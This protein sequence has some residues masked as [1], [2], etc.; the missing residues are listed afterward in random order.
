VRPETESRVLEAICD[1]RNGTKEAYDKFD[2]DRVTIW[3]LDVTI[4]L[5]PVRVLVRKLLEPRT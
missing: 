5:C 2:L 1:T 4:C 3:T